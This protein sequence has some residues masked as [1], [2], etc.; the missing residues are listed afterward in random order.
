MDQRAGRGQV[1]CPGVFEDEGGN[2]YFAPHQIVRA[3][4][5]LGCPVDKHALAALIGELVTAA[6]LE[7]RQQHRE[8]PARSGADDPGD[9]P[10]A[11][12]GG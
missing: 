4:T 10:P 7:R 11:T 3:N 5:T 2:F 1:L 12:P 8:Q 9:D 6:A